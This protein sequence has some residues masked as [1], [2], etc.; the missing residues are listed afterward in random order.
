VQDAILHRLDQH[1]ADAQHDVTVLKET[2]KRLDLGL[3][4]LHGDAKTSQDAVRKLE[5]YVK[6]MAGLEVKVGVLRKE[7]NDLLFQL[8]AGQSLY[9]NLID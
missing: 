2:V 5:E 7:V 6:G 4:R 3:Y 9:F 1:V 8:P